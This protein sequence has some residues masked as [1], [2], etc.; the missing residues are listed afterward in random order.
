MLRQLELRALAESDWPGVTALEA[1]TY[2]PLGLSEDPAALRSRAAASPRTNLVLAD[3]PDRVAGYLLSLPYPDGGFPD[4]ARVETAA[5]RAD[6]PD[7]LHIHDLVVAREHRSRGLAERLL[8]RLVEIASAAGYRQL[9]G[10][11]VNGAHARWERSGF[12]SHPEVPIPDYYGPG[13]V[14]IRR[15]LHSPTP[16]GR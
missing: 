9:S 13:A 3:G 14:Y 15:P 6:R 10:V 4:L 16:E 1:E 8:D 7:N 11:A 12:R 5:A 2:G